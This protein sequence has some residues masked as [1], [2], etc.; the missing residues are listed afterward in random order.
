M[1]N[2]M[3]FSDLYRDR[4]KQPEPKTAGPQ[5][6]DS[7][8]DTVGL[9]DIWNDRRNPDEWQPDPNPQPPRPLATDRDDVYEVRPRT[10]TLEEV[11]DNLRFPSA[12]PGVES[13]AIPKTRD[14][15]LCSTC[16]TPLLGHSP[17]GDH[18]PEPFPQG[19]RTPGVNHDVDSGRARSTQPSG[20]RSTTRFGL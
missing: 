19:Q 8:A 12:H 16:M 14:R 9:P 4:R 11:L 18:V 13:I 7:A 10:M 6:V 17:D 5:A 20:W 15:A 1:A 2:R 3:G